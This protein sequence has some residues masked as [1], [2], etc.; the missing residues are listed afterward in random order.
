MSRGLSSPLKTALAS[1]EIYVALAGEFM[2]QGG[3]VR[4]WTGP[5]DITWNSTTFNGAGDLVGVEPVEE[6]TAIVANGMTFTLSGI[7]STLVYKAL[8]DKYRHRPCKLWLWLTD[9]TFTTVQY[10]VLIFA[11]RMDTMA[12]SRGPENSTISLTAENRL[13]DL[14]RARSARWTDTEHKRRYPTDRFFEYTANIAERVLNWGGQ[15]ASGSKSGGGTSIDSGVGIGGRF[16]G[17]LGNVPVIPQIPTPN[18][19]EGISPDRPS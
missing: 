10:S 13:I 18:G 12:I 11:G 9:S 2:F 8:A 16:G 4:I 19:P 17:F 6:T 3:A 7:P 5:A 14:K 15:V 1:R